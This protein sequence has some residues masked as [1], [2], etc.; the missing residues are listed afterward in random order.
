[1]YVG[2]L[3]YGYSKEKNSYYFLLAREH[4]E[5]GWSGSETWSDFGGKAEGTNFLHEAA[6]GLWEE[7][8]GILGTLPDLTTN[9]KNG[10]VYRFTDAYIYLLPIPVDFN[11][12]YR[13]YSVY[14]YFSGCM[15]PSKEKKGYNYIPTCPEGRLEK[16]A[17]KWF[18]LQEIQT[19]MKTPGKYRLRPEFIS[20]FRQITKKGLP[21]I[22]NKI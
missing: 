9:L 16:T 18:S 21:K 14:D 19:E 20:S 10:V 7:S 6:R 11:I 13:F 1:M 2:F 5:T 17:M 22:I 3:P 15:K 12:P 4:A 8:M